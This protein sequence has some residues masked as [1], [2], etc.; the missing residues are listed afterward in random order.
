MYK[1]PNHIKE[2][3]QIC[4]PWQGLFPEK[5]RKRERRVMQSRRLHLE[6]WGG[7]GVSL[8]PQLFG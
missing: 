7:G 1:Y 2:K 3:T 6:I 5:K 8:Y 4:H